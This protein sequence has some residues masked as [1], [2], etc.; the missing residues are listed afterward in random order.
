VLDV[1]F[2]H[3]TPEGRLPVELPRSMADV[4]QHPEDLPGGF[5]DPLFPLGHG[6]PVQ[7]WRPRVLQDAVTG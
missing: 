1:V 7:H 2:G 6:L 5:P 4:E 3:A